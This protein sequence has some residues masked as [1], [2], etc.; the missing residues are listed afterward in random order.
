M[1]AILGIA[2]LVTSV[3]SQAVEVTS[4]A[5]NTTSLERCSGVTPTPTTRTIL[6]ISLFLQRLMLIPF[7]ES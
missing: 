1:I 7:D 3:L 6:Y 5:S 4:L 2:F